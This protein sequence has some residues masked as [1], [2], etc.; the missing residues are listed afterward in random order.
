M[1]N[2]LAKDTY[3]RYEVSTPEPATALDSQD[4]QDLEE[5]LEVA[6][7]RLWP[8]QTDSSSF[9]PRR[10]KSIS[11]TFDIRCTPMPD[12][13]HPRAIRTDPY[14]HRWPADFQRQAK[15][16]RTMT[17]KESLPVNLATRG[18]SHW[19]WNPR[20]PSVDHRRHQ[21]VAVRRSLPGYWTGVLGESDH[22]D[23]LNDEAS[24]EVSPWPASSRSL[25][26]DP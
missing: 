7:P 24:E 17:L 1:A 8:A 3:F 22:S 6:K 18:L 12:Y 20:S 11:Q 26:K 2:Q 9:E 10:A 13:H 25:E 4:S 15:S 5:M 23:G 16:F 19:L 21:R 14:T